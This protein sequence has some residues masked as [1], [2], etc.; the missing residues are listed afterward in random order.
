MCVFFVADGVLS[1]NTATVYRGLHFFFTFD[2]LLYTGGWHFFLHLTCYCTVEGFA[3]FTFGVSAVV[4]V[5]LLLLT[6]YGTYRGCT[7]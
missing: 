4:G 6:C 7:F 2:M 5:P 1:S 3:H